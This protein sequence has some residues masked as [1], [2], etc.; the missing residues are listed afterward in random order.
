M[1]SPL[2]ARGARAAGFTLIE[3]MIGLL[4]GVI[5]IV[6]IMET[7]AVSEG[8]KRTATTGSD[9]QTSGGIALYLLEREIRIA[10]YGMN[11]LVANGCTSVVAYNS[12]SG[13]SSSMRLVPFEINPAG[14]PA[15]DPNTD[16]VMVAYGTAGDFVTGI[17]ADQSTQAGDYTVYGNFDAYRAGDVVIAYQPPSAAGLPPTCAL[18][19]ITAVPGA[20][21]NCSGAS[22]SSGPNVLG[23]GTA[24]FENSY[25]GCSR[26]APIHNSAS[27]VR[28]PS[29]VAIPPL[30]QLSGGQ[31]FNLGGT[32]VV[33]IYAIRGGNLTMCD[34]LASDCT[35]VASYNVLVNNIVSLRAIYGQDTTV[36]LDGRIDQWTRAPLATSAQVSATVA[37]A[38][39]ITAKNPLREKPSSGTTCDATPSASRPD[40]VQDWFGPTLSPNDGTVA[41]GQIDLTATATAPDDFRCYRYKLF[42]SSVPIRNM[43]W[44]PS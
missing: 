35:N 39:E 7:F 15:G 42:Q 1:R 16:V 22:A 20:S 11:Q 4:I 32:P 13:T 31:L 30:Q 23:H 29:G 41:T 36:P 43:I 21:G 33:K 38:L 34:A 27:G 2:S 14:I 6:V 40:R 44:S 12:S 28:D 17:P 26:T 25:Q 19:D 9:A 18:A 5:G 10:G 8:Y 24:Q 3:I 37:V